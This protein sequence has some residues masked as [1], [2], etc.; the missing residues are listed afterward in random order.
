MYEG[1]KRRSRSGETM[2]LCLFFSVLASEYRSC[3]VS[4]WPRTMVECVRRSRY[5]QR[6][7]K[8][9]DAVVLSR[10]FIKS[11]CDIAFVLPLV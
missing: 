4:T 7:G 9:I 11:L 2:V 3:V 6:K 1:E 8:E 10:I 5:F